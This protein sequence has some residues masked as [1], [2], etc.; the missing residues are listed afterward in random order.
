MKNLIV[1]KRNLSKYRD[2]ILLMQNYS[3]RQKLFKNLRFMLI[4]NCFEKKSL[5]FYFNQCFVTKSLC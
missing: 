2:K 1:K 3:K 5:T 4:K